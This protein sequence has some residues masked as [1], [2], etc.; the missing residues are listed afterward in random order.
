MSAALSRSLAVERLM[1]TDGEAV[2]AGA[3]I[4]G[5]TSPGSI[6]LTLRTIGKWIIEHRHAVTIVGN[7]SMK[8]QLLGVVACLPLLVTGNIAANASPYVVTFEQIGLDVVATG[9][10]NIDLT[11]LTPLTLHSGFTAGVN[12]PEAVVTLSSSSASDLYTGTFSGPPAGVMGP[13]FG[14]ELVL[15]L[16]LPAVAPEISYL[17]AVLLVR[18]M[19]L[20]ATSL[21]IPWAPAWIL[22]TTRPSRASA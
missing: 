20:R 22:G 1:K 18:Y 13:G 10:G 9:S 12:P 2:Y 14:P 15:R 7:T 6:H 21:M 16:S 11:G 3:R 5:P 17:S 8:V 4:S 19:S